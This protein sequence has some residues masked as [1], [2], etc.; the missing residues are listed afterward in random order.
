MGLR[1]KNVTLKATEAEHAAWS[2]AAKAD[3]R[4][5][6]QW[7]ARRAN[8]EPTTPPMMLAPPVFPPQPAQ[9]APAVPARRR[10]RL[11]GR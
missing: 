5:L 4:T 10:P 8:G 9:P 2:A 3:G 6:S 1:T 11:K 7:L